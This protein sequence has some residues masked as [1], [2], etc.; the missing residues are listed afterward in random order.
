MPVPA[1]P[2]DVAVNAAKHCS[3]LGNSVAADH[4]S[5]QTYANSAMIADATIRRDFNMLNDPGKEESLNEDIE[6]ASC[7]AGCMTILFYAIVFLSLGTI[8]PWT[9]G[10]IVYAVFITYKLFKL[11]CKRRLIRRL[12]VDGWKEITPD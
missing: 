1:G 7:F 9:S 4:A 6:S 12:P 10:A 2:P 3:P 5:W 8:P 11:R